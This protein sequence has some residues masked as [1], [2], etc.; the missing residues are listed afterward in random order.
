MKKYLVEFIGAF[1]LVLTV[2]LTANNPDIAP[3]APL[4]IGSMYMV[5]MYA[6]GHI[7]GGHFNPAVTIAARIRGKMEFNDTI[8]YM[9]AQ[10]FGAAVA[11]AIGAYLHGSG[12]GAAIP[13]H[14]NSDP[15]ASLLCELLGTFALAYVVLNVN[16]TESNAGNS[17]YGLAGGFTLM[18][19]SYGFGSIS[20]GA[21][22]PAVS[23]GAAV[24]GMISTGDLWIYLAGSFAGGAAAANVFLG[25]YGRED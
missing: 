19:I 13:L 8:M 21:F 16:T 18:A 6:G 7:S 4:A 23:L 24:A 1:F 25:L 2:V 11:A 3:M 20:G 10:F 17:H 14:T 9:V 22:N 5:M 15:F 12:G